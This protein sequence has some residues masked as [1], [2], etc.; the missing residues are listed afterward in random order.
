M[1]C[2]LWSPHLSVDA[3]RKR[4]ANRE[5]MVAFSQETRT[6]VAL[7]AHKLMP[8]GPQ[9]LILV[10]DDALEHLKQAFFGLAFTDDHIK[11]PGMVADELF[12]GVDIE[13]AVT[14][15]SLVW[16]VI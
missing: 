15:V 8:G 3:V 14:Q 4:A 10:E 12:E 7:S 6:G 11:A 13:S 1:N 5:C 16:N 2:R 9:V